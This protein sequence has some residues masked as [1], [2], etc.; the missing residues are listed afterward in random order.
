[1]DKFILAELEDAYFIED[2][3]TYILGNSLIERKWSLEGGYF[4]TSSFK[5]LSTGKEWCKGNKPRNHHDF[6]Y[7]GLI[8]RREGGKLVFS[9]LSIENVTFSI[10]ESEGLNPHL[11]V[12]FHLID[13][14]PRTKIKRFY[15]IFPNTCAMVTWSEVCTENA[16][17][18]DYFLEGRR[19]VVDFL[20]LPLEKPISGRSVEFFTR[21]DVNNK[22]VQETP[23]TQDSPMRLNGNL[24]FLTDRRDGEGLFILKESPV[25]GDRRPEILGDFIFEEDG[26]YTFG[27]GIRP[28]EALPYRFRRSYSVVTGLYSG[29]DDQ[30]LLALKEYQMAKYRFLPERD[31]MVMANPWGDGNCYDR[32]GEDFILEELEGCARIGATHYQ[33]DDGWQ[34]GGA[35]IRI[36]NNEVVDDDFW[37]IDGNRFPEAFT[38]LAQR[39]SELGVNLTLWFAPDRNR[40]YR[41]NKRDGQILWRM[42]KDF[43]IKAF[44][45]DALNI[46]TKEAEE[47]LESLLK[48]LA[49]RSNG[50]IS[51]NFDVTGALDR[52]PGYFHLQEYGNIFLENRYTRIKGNR[53][54][55]YYPFKTL[56]N[57]WQLAPY[58][59]PQKLQVEFL[60]IDLNQENYEPDHELAPA[61][62]PWEYVFAITF[63]ANPL[64]WGEPSGFSDEAVTRIRPLI[65]LHKAY[66][67]D[68]FSCNIFSIGDMPDGYAWTGFQAHPREDGLGYLI[69]YRERHPSKSHKIGLKFLEEGNYEFELITSSSPAPKFLISNG[70]TVEC[71]LDSMNS[72]ALYSYVLG[73]S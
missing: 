50:D 57:L 48:D 19:N 49:Q 20:P 26:V 34:K 54:N 51:F 12:I 11:E 67:E 6:A 22:L 21:S 29:H 55:K 71:T 62:Y 60:N 66:R 33:I 64:L 2:G 56:R 17:A 59:L 4:V 43:N 30:G 5:N 42:Y 72:F 47:N 9:P 53:A 13:P 41:N 58:V 68:I 10:K 32:L 36:I 38:P 61:N 1:M 73:S 40:L 7:E 14:H 8:G 65:D 23:F 18:G 15:R 25:S 28:E 24:L 70:G 27:W 37:T 63:F 52:R 31:Y 44:K 46:Q 45:I 69:I 3:S 35:L 39:A 16:P